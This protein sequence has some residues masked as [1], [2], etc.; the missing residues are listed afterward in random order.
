MIAVWQFNGISLC[1][2]NNA[3]F[4]KNIIRRNVFISVWEIFFVT[5]ID[6]IIKITTRRI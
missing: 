5:A 2:F 4:L 6:T 3:V 1:V